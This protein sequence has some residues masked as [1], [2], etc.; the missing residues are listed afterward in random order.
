MI[1]SKNIRV[2][3]T[4]EEKIALRA[5]AK[6]CDELMDIEEIV[7][8]YDIDFGETYANLLSIINEDH[9]QYADKE[10]E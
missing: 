2:Q 3:L 9:F 1:I 5:A 10:K 6:I 8:N 4:A 7:D